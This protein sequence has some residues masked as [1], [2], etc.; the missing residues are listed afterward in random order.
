MLSF[1]LCLFAGNGVDPDVVME[2][3]LKDQ[4]RDAVSNINLTLQFTVIS[5]SLS[6]RWLAQM[7]FLSTQLIYTQKYNR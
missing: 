5:L 3:T 6:A 7:T 1:K 4:R 2:P